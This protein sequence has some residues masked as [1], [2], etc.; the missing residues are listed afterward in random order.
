M[1][2][3]CKNKIK[4]NGITLISLIITIIVL[5]II[6]GVAINTLYGAN[7]I[8]TTTQDVVVLSN[9]KTLEEGIDLYKV[10]SNLE[11]KVEEDS[12]PIALSEDGSRITLNQMKSSSELAKLPDEVKYTLLNLTTEKGT[13]NIPSLD[14]I[15][16][17]KFY[18]LDY[19]KL[20]I[21]QEEAENLVIYIDGDTYKVINLAGVKYKKS[22]VYVIIP[23]NNEAE[24]EYITV[25][26]NT[27]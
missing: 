14:Q 27:Y 17:S 1:D 5:L 20:S 6:S 19:T 3:K 4:N 8:I 16:Y 22:N 7:G 24:P 12:Y 26:N 21:S 9:I 15:D 23:L 25:A 13:T 2:L 11:G 10:N 18:K